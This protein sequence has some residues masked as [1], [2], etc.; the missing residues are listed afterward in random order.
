MFNVDE[1][2]PVDTSALPPFFNMPR[3]FRISAAE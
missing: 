1:V 3:P 2:F